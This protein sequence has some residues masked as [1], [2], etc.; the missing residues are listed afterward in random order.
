MRRKGHWHEERWERNL[1]E[2]SV[3]Y[4]L[5]LQLCVFT[6]EMC[7]YEIIVGKKNS[8]SFLLTQVLYLLLSTFL[9]LWARSR[10]V[11]FVPLHCLLWPFS[12]PRYIFYRGFKCILKVIESTLSFYY[13]KKDGWLKLKDNKTRTKYTKTRDSLLELN[14]ECRCRVNRNY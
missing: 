9:L 12:L 11:I 13:Y 1:S 14:E 3:V 10:C 4:A 5:V 2:G 8:Y 7:I 6:T